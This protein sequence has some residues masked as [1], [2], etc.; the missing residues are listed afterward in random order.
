MHC[1]YK[2]KMTNETQHILLYIYLHSNSHLKYSC[3]ISH[4][5]LHFCNHFFFFAT[6]LVWVADLATLHILIATET[7]KHNR[8][9]HWSNPAAAVTTA[10]L[11]LK[12][13]PNM[14]FPLLCSIRDVTFSDNSIFSEEGC[15][16]LR[17]VNR[18]YAALL[19]FKVLFFFTSNSS[20][21][22]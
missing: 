11:F 6:A 9:P 20:W 19:S 14:D 22:N 17:S 5:F 2:I 21:S 12:K 15:H 13:M 7:Q 3:L 4:S 18:V 1:F 8:R 10:H 16:C